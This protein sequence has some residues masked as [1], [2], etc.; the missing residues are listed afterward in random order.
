M[1]VLTRPKHNC[2]RVEDCKVHNVSHIQRHLVQKTLRFLDFSIVIFFFNFFH[3]LLSLSLEIFFKKVW[4]NC[5]FL[6]CHYL[7]LIYF[8]TLFSNTLMLLLKRLRSVLNMI[9]DYVLN[10]FFKTIYSIS[11]SLKVIKI[12]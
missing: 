3:T 1:C 4:I 7:Y 2:I 11:I 12:K 9:L 6:A 8:F 10:N 5:C